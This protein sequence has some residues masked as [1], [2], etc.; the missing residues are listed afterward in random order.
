[1]DNRDMGTPDR[2]VGLIEIDPHEPSVLHSLDNQESSGL[3]FPREVNVIDGAVE[4][5]YEDRGVRS[6]D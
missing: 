5:V 1:M 6:G 2:M 3:N 4:D